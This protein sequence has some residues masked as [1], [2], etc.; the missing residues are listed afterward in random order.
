M[1]FG[2]RRGN[3]DWL[4]EVLKVIGI[5]DA[6]EPITADL[7]NHLCVADD[8]LLVKRLERK[9][10]KFALVSNNGEPDIEDVDIEW[11]AKV[12]SMRPR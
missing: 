7:H 10:G 5:L 3:P 8:R 12:T 9:R 1:L 6:V 11:A 2:V 4:Q